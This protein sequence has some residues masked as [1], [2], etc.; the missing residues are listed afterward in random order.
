MTRGRA[1]MRKTK[2]G[3]HYGAITAKDYAV[4]GAL[5]FQFANWNTGFCFPSYETIA[6]VAGCSR[7]H[8]AVAIKRLEAAGL[9]TWVNRLKW[10]RERC[11]DLF[12]RDGLQKRALRTS[13]SYRFFDPGE[14]A[15]LQFSSKS[16]NQ[17][18]TPNQD[19]LPD[20]ERPTTPQTAPSTKLEASLRRCFD[21]LNR[22]SGDRA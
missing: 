19:S 4:L 11:V 10:V 6:E 21:L 8:V 16:K 2:K 9:L 3:K 13:N 22:K 15:I 12:G 20:M 1:L 17:T 18:R 14:T 5:L 7:S